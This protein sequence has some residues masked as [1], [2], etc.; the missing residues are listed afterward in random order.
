MSKGKASTVDTGKRLNIDTEPNVPD[1]TLIARAALRPTVNAAVTARVFLSNLHSDLDL[2]ELVTELSNQCAKA[3]GGDLSRAEGMLTAQSH[4]LDAMFGS[5]ARRA[6]ANLREYPD[7]A[8]RYMRLALKAQSQ[9]RATVETL[10]NLRNPPMVIARQA[11]ISHG[12]QQVNN[13]P[14]PRAE[15]I[16]STPN[17]LLEQTNGERLDTGAASEAIGSDPALAT[18]GAVH[19][20][21]NR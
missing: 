8:E 1:A 5:L 4:T 13:G 6:H 15:G 21:S 9:C 18:V 14:F 19:R 16:E 7:A 10:G 17:E 12:P 2:S 20:P 3:S 11:N